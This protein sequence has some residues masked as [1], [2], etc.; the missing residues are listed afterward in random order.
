MVLRSCDLTFAEMVRSVLAEGGMDDE[1]LP[2][3]RSS[4]GVLDNTWC[5][6]A[7]RDV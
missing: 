3:N 1:P 7:L 5:A 2:S 4:I 6:F